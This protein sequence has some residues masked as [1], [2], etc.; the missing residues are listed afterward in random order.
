MGRQRPV[1]ICVLGDLQ[2]RRRDGTDVRVEEWR[3]GKTRDLLR[4]LALGNGRP[5]RADLLTE[6]LWPGVPSHRARNSLRTAASQIRVT[7]KDRSVVRHPDGLVLTGAVLDAEQY[8]SM[9]LSAGVAANRRDFA[10]VL[11]IARAAEA[12]YRDDFHADDDDSDW[13]V[14]ERTRLQQARRTLACDAAEA[15]LCERRP[16]E[17]LAFA[18]VAVELDP[19]FETAHRLLMRAQAAMGEVAAALR[20]FETYRIRLADEL[21]VD[22]SPE[23]RALH[24]ELLRSS[25][26]ERP[27]G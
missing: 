8:A 10:A 26:A 5:V 12:L 23:T 24:L 14:A 3:T 20:D 25:T 27:T 13:A 1:R 15:A 19:M 21:G 2:V 4:L 16:R 18:S 17:A 6:L 11:P 7:L 22:P 9:A